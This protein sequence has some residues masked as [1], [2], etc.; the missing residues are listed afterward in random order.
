MPEEIMLKSLLGADPILWFYL[1]TTRCQ[2]EENTANLNQQ[3]RRRSK[4]GIN[5]RAIAAHSSSGSF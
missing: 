2:V 5:W 4:P 3:K 1:Q